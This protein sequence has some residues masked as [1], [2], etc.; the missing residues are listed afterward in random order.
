MFEKKKQE[1]AAGMQPLPTQ[2]P[3]PRPH[4]QHQANQENSSRVGNRSKRSDRDLYS[5]DES[6]DSFE[7]AASHLSRKP[8]LSTTAYSAQ[9]EVQQHHIIE[10][11]VLTKMKM[12]TYKPHFHKIEGKGVHS[13]FILEGYLRK[14]KESSRGVYAAEVARLNHFDLMAKPVIPNVL[15][16]I[17]NP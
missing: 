7:D 17:R 9:S 12:K 10:E 2:P 8:K 13:H 11:T 1:Q 15:N 5:D 6:D 4:E 14:L 16:E 3:K